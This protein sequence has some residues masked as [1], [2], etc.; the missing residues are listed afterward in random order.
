MDEHRSHSMDTVTYDSVCIKFTQ[1]EWS[2]LDPSQKSLYKD[3]MLDTY[4]NLSAIG[5]IWEECNIEEHCESF[6]RHRR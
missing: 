3:V 4:R 2:L 6:R 1:E 5:Y